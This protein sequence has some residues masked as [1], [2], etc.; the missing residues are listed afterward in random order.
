MTSSGTRATPRR[1]AVHNPHAIRASYASRII[2]KPRISCPVPGIEVLTVTDTDLDRCAPKTIFAVDKQLG[3]YCVQG[4]MLAE[5]G[6]D[7]LTRFKEYFDYVVADDMGRD[8]A[9]ADAYAA[10]RIDAA[11]EHTEEDP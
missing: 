7:G 3:V 9:P 1:V 6:P 8:G 4:P 2:W 11:D 10:I 5:T